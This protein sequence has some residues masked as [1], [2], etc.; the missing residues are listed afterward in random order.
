MSP[1]NLYFEALRESVT[2]K[3]TPP[4]G[5]AKDRSGESYL[6]RVFLL[7]IFSFLLFLLS[8]VETKRDCEAREKGITRCV[9]GVWEIESLP[10]DTPGRC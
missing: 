3:E 4:M 2:N 1:I 5:T 7:S 8:F 10:Y 6:P 9:S